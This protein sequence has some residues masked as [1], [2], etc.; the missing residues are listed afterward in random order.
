MILD[1]FREM[2]MPCLKYIS[3]KFQFSQRGC[4]LGN[5]GITEQIINSTI[6]GQIY[7]ERVVHLTPQPLIE[8]RFLVTNLMCRGGKFYPSQN[9][10]PVFSRF[11]IPARELFCTMGNNELFEWLGVSKN[12]LELFL[13]V[14]FGII[15]TL[16][17]LYGILIYQKI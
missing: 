15:C 2:T 14:D 8:S 12:C 11:T 10:L 3:C 4:Y 7:K 17:Q 16:L 9:L 6:Y 13:S 1:E 5:T